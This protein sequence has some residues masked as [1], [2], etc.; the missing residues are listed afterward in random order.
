MHG[1]ERVDLVLDLDFLPTNYLGL[2]SWENGPKLICI[3]STR[4]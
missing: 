3:R 2:T 4:K 1:I